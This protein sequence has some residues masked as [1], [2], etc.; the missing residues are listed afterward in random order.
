MLFNLQVPAEWMNA[1]WLADVRPLRAARLI[2]TTESDQWSVLRRAAVGPGVKVT[3]T[4]ALP[5]LGARLRPVRLIG[6]TPMVIHIAGSLTGV[7][8]FAC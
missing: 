5:M 7:Q 8:R 6:A 4:V 1:F 3:L 2:E